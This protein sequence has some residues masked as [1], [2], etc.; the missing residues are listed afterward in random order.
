MFVQKET[1]VNKQ[2]Q[3]QKHLAVLSFPGLAQGVSLCP[4]GRLP[5][6]P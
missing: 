6:V 2:E 1:P 3:L 4:T 5:G